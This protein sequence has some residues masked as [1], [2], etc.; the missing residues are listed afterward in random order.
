MAVGYFHIA[1]EICRRLYLTKFV[2]GF[3]ETRFLTVRKT[4][5][6]H[7]II[8]LTPSS[9]R[10]FGRWY[11]CKCRRCTVPILMVLTEDDGTR[12]V[13]IVNDAELGDDL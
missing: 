7:S 5:V 2:V 8:A 12:Q 10:R 3:E 9:E 13:I 1:I 4:K 6:S 11:S